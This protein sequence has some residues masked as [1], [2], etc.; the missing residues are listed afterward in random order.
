M[1]SDNLKKVQ[2][3][4]NF[5]CQ[6]IGRNPEGIIL[7][8]VTKNVPVEKIKEVI[9]L[10]VINIGENRVQEALKKYSELAISH[11]PSA[12]SQ[13]KWH[14]VGHL[15]KNKVKYALK[16]FDLIHSV[17]DFELAEEIDKQAKKIG[18]IQDCLIEI[19]VSPE[20]TKYGCPPEPEEVKKLI[21]RISELANI[22][23]RGLMAMAPFF[24]KSEETRPYFR[25]AFECYSL[26]ATR[27]S[28]TYLS[29]GMSNDFTIA[30][31]EGANMLRIGTAIFK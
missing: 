10:D 17:D 20:V 24:E 28:L 23:I 30:L 15:Q 22:R 31:E 14:L 3:K 4:I 8:A 18:K 12:I 6:K 1:I 11:Q 16:I 27:Y 2:E 26:L 25:Q 29:M 7:V 19:K 21:E 13:V 9:F 5:T